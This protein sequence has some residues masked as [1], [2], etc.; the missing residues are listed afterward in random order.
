MNEEPEVVDWKN[1]P[2]LEPTFISILVEWHRNGAWDKLQ[3][4]RLNWYH[5][6]LH[7]NDKCKVNLKWDQY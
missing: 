2:T 3:K 7:M 5:L 4:G 6:A 1:H